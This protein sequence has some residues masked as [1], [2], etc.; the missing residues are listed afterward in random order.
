M[1]VLKQLG[2]MDLVVCL[3]YYGIWLEREI[4]KRKEEGKPGSYA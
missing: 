4:E 2:C 1:C 3:V